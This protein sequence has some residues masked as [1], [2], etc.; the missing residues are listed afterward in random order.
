MQAIKPAHYPWLDYRRYA[1]SL[2]RMGGGAAWL[3]GATAST[4]D[5]E[6]RHVEIRGGMA[7]QAATA[8]DKIEAVLEAAGLTLADVTRVTEYLPPDGV[9][10][11]AEL[12]ETRDAR[13]GDVRP[14]VNTAPVAALFRSGA[15]VEIE[16]LAGPRGSVIGDGVIHLP[17]LSPTLPNGD[18]AYPGDV[19]GQTARIF[20]RAEEILTDLGS[21]LSH[22]AMT[23]DFLSPAARNNYKSSG[24]VRLDR[25]GPVYPGA[26]GIV[27]PQ[28]MH[29]EALVQ[30]DITATRDEPERIDPGWRR[31][32]ALSYSAAVKAGPLVFLSGMGALDPEKLEFRH[33]DD[34]AAQ[35]DYIFELTEKAMHSAGG[36]LRDIVKQVEFVAPHAVDEY[37]SVAEVRRKWF[38]DVPPA[39]TGVTC[40]ALLRGAMRIEIVQVAVIGAG[41]V[42][43]A[44]A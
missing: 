8:W 4:W 38:G 42:E 12:A 7:Q 11:Y 43:D 33:A 2:G 34:I 27:Q 16:V 19:V 15:L 37:R 17:T 23:V 22:I 41:S 3:S 35:A 5:P 24:H 10:R 40:G 32:D 13:L 29:P 25:L 31:Y 28:L 26:A 44:N 21:D 18:I 6:T 14:T 36:A 30:Y 20:D 39:A 9:K 1:F